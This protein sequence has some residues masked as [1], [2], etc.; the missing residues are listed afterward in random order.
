VEGKNAIAQT[1]FDY[2]LKKVLT[3]KIKALSF[4]L[5]VSNDANH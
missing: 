2:S 5:E 4:L 1:F 3:G